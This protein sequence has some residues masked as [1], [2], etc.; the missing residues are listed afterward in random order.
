MIHDITYAV[1]FSLERV[2]FA[3]STETSEKL[4][5]DYVISA[6]RSYERLHY[7]KFVGAGIPTSLDKALPSF[8]PRLWLELDIVP[9]ALERRLNSQKPIKRLDEE[10]DSMARKCIMQVQDHLPSITLYT[11]NHL[12]T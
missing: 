11:V 12:V 1:D 2:S 8:S 9:V 3:E 5:V 6:I 7:C 10:A 4:V